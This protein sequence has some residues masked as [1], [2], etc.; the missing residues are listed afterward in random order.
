MTTRLTKVIRS[1]SQV[2][3]GRTLLSDIESAQSPYA[4][5]TPLSDAMSLDR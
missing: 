5:R 1:I 4:Q 3:E 2:P